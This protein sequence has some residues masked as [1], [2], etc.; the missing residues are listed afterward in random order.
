M[1][2]VSVAIQFEAADAAEATAIIEAWQLAD[3]T[4]IHVSLTEDLA[5]GIVEG[6]DIVEPDPPEIGD[7][8]AR[9]ATVEPPPPPDLPPTGAEPA[10]D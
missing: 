8:G 4:Q 5:G 10:E 9:T 1:A 2:T 6:G 3:G 7:N